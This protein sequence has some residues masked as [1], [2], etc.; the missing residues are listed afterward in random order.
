MCPAEHD[1]L[2]AAEDR[3]W[4]YAV[5]HR[6]VQTEM[7]ARVPGGSRVLD[8]GC[9]TGGMMAQLKQWDMHGLDIAPWAVR[10]CQQR[11]LT[12][13][14]HASLHDLP[15]ETASFDAMLSLDVLYHEQVDEHHALREMARV[16]KP[17]GILIMNLPAFDCLRGAH[18][19]AVRGARRYTAA[20]VR[21]RLRVHDLR[22]DVAHYWN[23]WLFLPM[24]LWRRWTRLHPDSAR[25]DVRHIPAWLNNALSRLGWLDARASRRLHLVGSSVFTIA[26]RHE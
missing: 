25:S 24:L 18:D 15:F 22:V 17:G 11:G 4:W 14:T 3:H 26:H 10:H 9:G 16:L 20:K 19:S 13:V 12:Q 21:E 8:A 6:L 1:I 7:Q 23:A 2:R 5:L